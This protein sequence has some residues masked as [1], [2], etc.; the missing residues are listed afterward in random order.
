MISENIILK[1]IY[2]DLCTFEGCNRDHVS[3][4]YCDK[5]YRHLKRYGYP[6]KT[7]RDM[8]EIDRFNSKIKINIQNGCHEW[9]D[10]LCVWGYGM[11][12]LKKSIQ[13]KAHRYAYELKNGKIP[14]GMLIC[15]HCDNPKCV[16]VDHL[17]LGTALDNNL[18]KIK[19]GRDNLPKGE[20]HFRTKVKEEVVIL[21][22]KLLKNI[23][24]PTLIARSLNL[25]VHFV[26][27]IKYNKTWKHV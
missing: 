17:F 6:K 26:E 18:D 24:S 20:D 15:H 9:T 22:K 10:K 19:K 3:K 16:N 1:K 27:S 7:I 21:V 25:P 8:S 2:P 23:S 13:V 14:K 12:S 11:F 5:H 4:G